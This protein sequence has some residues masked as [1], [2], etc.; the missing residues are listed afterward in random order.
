MQSGL[1]LQLFD[2]GLFYPYT[3]F[4]GQKHTGFGFVLLKSGFAGLVIVRKRNAY[5]QEHQCID[6]C[7]EHKIPMRGHYAH[8][9]E[10]YAP[11]HKYFAEVVGVAGI[12]PYAYAIKAFLT[13]FAKLV[14]KVVGCALQNDRTYRKGKEN[15]TTYIV[16][17][18]VVQGEYDR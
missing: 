17:W 5:K 13:A 9:C 1:F 2:R 6:K 7:A 15:Y 12:L 4:N 14:H 11:P 16:A 18:C 10:S 8:K 3:L